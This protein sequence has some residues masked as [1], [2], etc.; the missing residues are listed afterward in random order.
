MEK[1]NKKKID[2][3]KFQTEEQQEIIRFLKILLIILMFLG[4][5]YF[6]TTKVLKKDGDS[7]KVVTEGK[8]DYDKMILGTLFNQ[9]YDEYYVFVYDGNS[10]KAIYYSA[11]IDLYM[12][13][14][15]SKKIYWAD[16][17]NYLNK[18]FIAN[19][20]SEINK[21]AK[22]LNE[23][24]VGEYT[25]IKISNKKITK[26]IDNIEDTKKELGLNN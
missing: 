8:I 15:D 7:E 17:N 22:K 14:D 10:N 9:N 24:K 1:N 25:L 16:L 21:K 4:G 18:K 6:V 5:I 20:S 13:K 2:I 26:Y 23:L 11:L 19:D 12:K 3:N